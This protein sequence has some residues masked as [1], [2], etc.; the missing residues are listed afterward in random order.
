V[1]YL[2]SSL[3][4]NF[5]QYCQIQEE[6]PMKFRGAFGIFRTISNCYIFILRFLPERSLISTAVEIWSW[7]RDS[8]SKRRKRIT[9]LRWVTFQKNE[10]FK[11]AAVESLT[12]A[13]KT[14]TFSGSESYSYFYENWRLIPAFTK[15]HHWQI[16]RTTWISLHPISW[17][18]S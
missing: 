17:K 1:L 10:I 6:I 14:C 12:L 5:L 15:V 11:H 8:P 18:P 16:S 9:H 3:H 4:Q 7:K 2:A 13:T